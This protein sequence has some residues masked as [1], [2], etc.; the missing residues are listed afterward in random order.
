MSQATTVIIDSDSHS[1]TN[2]YNSD[3]NDEEIEE[4]MYDYISNS[5]FALSL[6]KD[7]NCWK[8]LTNESIRDNPYCI[9]CRKE[10]E[11]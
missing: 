1:S 7:E 6:L 9:L 3:N 4:A 11:S 5:V 8:F 2:D 10:N